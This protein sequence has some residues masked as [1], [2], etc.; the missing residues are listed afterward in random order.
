MLQKLAD[1]F[2]NGPLAAERLRLVGH[3]DP[4]G[5]DEHDLALGGRRAESVKKALTG[6]GLSS[7]KASTTSRGE[8]DAAGSDEA[9]WAKD[10][11][12]QVEVAE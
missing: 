7:D 11:R 12:V 4:R 6:F 5:D 3:T 10:R 8:M 9:S 2:T 1:C